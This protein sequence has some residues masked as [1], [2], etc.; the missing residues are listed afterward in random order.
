M[1]AATLLKK[2]SEYLLENGK[3]PV[4]VFAF[5]KQLKIEEAIFYKHFSSFGHLEAAFFSHWFEATLKA[6][7]KV[8]EYN[9]YTSQEK[10]LTF[11]FGFFEQLTANRSLVLLILK[12]SGG[13][14]KLNQLRKLRGKLIEFFSTLEFPSPDLP[15]KEINKYKDKA[16]AEGAWAQFL[17]IL[18]YWLND[19]SPSFEK[20]DI[21]IEKSVDTGFSLMASSPL[22]K[23][24]DLGK[25]LVKD[26]F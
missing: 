6:C 5:A 7:N 24:L 8:K 17:F 22:E 10:L 18:K 3:R 4:T 12:D 9:S 16:V 21:L 23:V 14:N 26:R 19:E 11:Y 2:Y 1:T 15:M 25:F 13:I 20:T